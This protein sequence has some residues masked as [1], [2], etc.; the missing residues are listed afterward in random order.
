MVSRKNGYD[1]DNVNSVKVYSERYLEKMHKAKGYPDPKLRTN[2]LSQ[3][4]ISR[5]DCFDAVERLEGNVTEGMDELVQSGFFEATFLKDTN[6]V[7]LR[8]KY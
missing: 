4:Y 1:V 5:L 8:K 3:E 2:P 7:D 6:I